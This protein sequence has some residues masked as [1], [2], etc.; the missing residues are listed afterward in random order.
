MDYLVLPRPQPRRL[1]WLAVPAAGL[2]LL[3]VQAQASRLETFPE[4]GDHVD[5]ADFNAAPTCLV[6]AAQFI[7][8]HAGTSDLLQ[9]EKLDPALVVTSIAERQSYVASGTFGGH[10]AEVRT[11]SDALA[12]VLA[13]GDA[14]SLVE[15][16]R[17]HGVTWYVA[18]PDSPW[19]V[20]GPLAKD[21]IYRCGG[22]SV[23]RFER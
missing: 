21:V 22:F 12:T 23:F 6:E 16:A 8:K 14:D 9:D 2:L 1:R 10:S 5:Y 19:Q 3:G 11:R 4:W 15:W 13:S 7:R 17:T 18:H 20:G